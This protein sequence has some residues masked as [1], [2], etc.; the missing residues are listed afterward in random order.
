ML[1]GLVAVVLLRLFLPVQILSAGNRRLLTLR[2]VLC[3]GEIM[4][5]ASFLGTD[6][7]SAPQAQCVHGPP[8][9][10]CHQSIERRL[11][12]S[13]SSAPQGSAHLRVVSMQRQFLMA[14]LQHLADHGEDRRPLAAGLHHGLAVHPARGRRVV[15]VLCYELLER[16]PDACKPSAV[17]RRKSPD[18]PLCISGGPQWHSKDV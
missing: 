16:G 5:G 7:K 15:P 12:T 2:D 10:R 3:S 1:V 11:P 8:K 6:A 17:T 13:R 18:P 14:V 4:P 9:L